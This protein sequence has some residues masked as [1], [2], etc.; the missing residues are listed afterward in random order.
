MSPGDFDAEVFLKSLPQKPG[1]YRMLDADGQALYVGKARSLKARVTSYFRASGLAAKTIALVNRIADVQITVTSSETEALLLEQSLIKSERPPYNVVLR[2]DKSYPYIHLTDHTDYPRLTF[3][4]G[5]K[6]KTGRYFGPF[7]SAGAVR[8]SLNILQKLFRLRHCDDSFFKNRSRPCLQYQIERCS[9][10]C[11]GFIDPEGYREDVELAVMFLEGRSSA[12]LE[13]FKARMQAAAEQLDFERA[14][15]FRDQIARL[16]RV[17]ESQYVHAEEG[18]VDLF[19]LQEGAGVCCVQALFVR[20][21]RILGQRTWFPKNELALP[22]DEL[23][24]AFLSQYYLGGPERD[25]PRTVITAPGMHDADVLAAALTGKGGRRVDVVHQVRAQ[26]AR[27]LTLAREN[28]A[29]S[30]NAYLA[31]KRNVYARLVALQEGLGLDDLPARLECFDISHT[32]GEATVASCVVFDSNG[33]LKSDYRRFNIEGV[34]AGDDYGAME[35][36][37]RRRYTRLKQGEGKLPDVLV[38][39]GGAGQVSR[40]QEV[41]DELQV[42]DVAILGI[43]KGPSRKPGLEK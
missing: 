24:E 41:L 3:H 11:V 34:A 20:A 12:V 33:P 28:A 8:E 30:L 17:Q 32:M 13:V 23:L 2:D 31:D 35:Q 22:A 10:P 18:D 15:K 4:R 29:H 43:A 36:A 19:A 21:G 39:D 40:A 26:R 14:A 7:P 27:W 37:L 25:L 6:K 42:D 38:V 1:V 9:G 16:R 5:A